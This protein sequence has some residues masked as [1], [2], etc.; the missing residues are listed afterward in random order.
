MILTI[1]SIFLFIIFITC[2]VFQYR[3]N[4]NISNFAKLSN[5]ELE[6]LNYVTNVYLACY[7]AY[8]IILTFKYILT[9]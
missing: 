3:Y 8:L 7:I 6:V 5:S 4:K 2:V 1:T 9:S